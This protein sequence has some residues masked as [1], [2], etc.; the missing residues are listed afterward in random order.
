MNKHHYSFNGRLLRAPFPGKPSA[1]LARCM[2]IEN[3][4]DFSV[5]T[6]LPNSDSPILVN[7]IEHYQILAAMVTQANTLWPQNL[8][9]L[10]RMSMPSG[11]RLPK[12]LLLQNVLLIQDV[13]PEIKRLKTSNTD[14][15][16]IEDNFIR[17]QLESGSNTMNIS[18]FS[19]SNDSQ[20]P[21]NELLAPL[22]DWGV[23]PL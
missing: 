21:F 3:E 13:A 9:I 18:L 22:S 1:A 19:Q 14:L 23:E 4:N 5:F 7:F 10:V 12:P 16:V 6:D 8:S 15:L 17:Y 20:A 2:P 11:M